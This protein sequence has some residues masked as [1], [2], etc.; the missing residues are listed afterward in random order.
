LSAE[1]TEAKTFCSDNRGPKNKRQKK[2]GGNTPAEVKNRESKRKV[3][4][5]QQRPVLKRG[6]VDMFHTLKGGG[7]LRKHG[8]SSGCGETQKGEK[9]ELL[10]TPGFRRGQGGGPI[11]PCLT[12][13]N[14]AAPGKKWG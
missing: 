13:S 14:G 4:G 5:Y 9:E 6:R 12:S 7:N 11:K 8:R 1:K 10:P 2:K 3:E